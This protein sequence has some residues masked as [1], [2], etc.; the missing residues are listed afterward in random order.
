[1]IVAFAPSAVTIHAHRPDSSA[2]NCWSARVES[3]ET[4]GDL[5]RVALAGAVAAV[6]DV[7]PLAVAELGL[8]PGGEVWAT[9]KAAET[10]V[11]PA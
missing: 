10:T 8:R 5:V 1:V 6:A 2:R 3:V 9:V 4:H 7:T 11:Y